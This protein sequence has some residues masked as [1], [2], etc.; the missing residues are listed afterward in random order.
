MEADSGMG[1]PF[2]GIATFFL[3]IIG[4]P[5]FVLQFISPEERRVVLGRRFLFEMGLFILLALLVVGAALVVK[6]GPGQAF[7]DEAVWGPMYLLLFA[8]SIGVIIRIP[9]HYGRREQIVKDLKRRASRNLSENGRFDE[10]AL[11]DL[12][13]LGKQCGSGQEQELVLQALDELVNEACCCSHY[14]AG[15]LELIIDETV[16]ML[17]SRPHPEDFQSF[18]T[19]VSLL[20]RIV[21][22]SPREAGMESLTDHQRAVRALSALG[23][24][25]LS[26]VGYSIGVDYI[27][28][29]YEEAL[30]LALLNH[31]S[32]LTDVSQALTET[33]AV[34]LE[35]KHYL[36]AVAALERLLSIVEDS[37][38][39]HDEANTDM[40]GLLAHFWT[41]S[42]SS[43]AFAELRL[44]RVKAAVQPLELALESACK[45]CQITMEFD[46]AD[47]II[48]MARDLEDQAQR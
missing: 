1:I 4:V 18:R 32:L 2:E 5:A 36:F 29:G 48:A 35:S 37:Q 6:A 39:G 43:H 20:R 34:A 44:E 42:L 8:V 12:A 9:N 28:M 7:S 27:L 47:K 30:S 10:G 17:V 3:F 46:T 26:Q 23:Q 13:G 41:G 31:P 40:L 15:M 19:A 33:G 21:I 38:A 22:S 16:N 11:A 45:H 24:A 25:V 14:R